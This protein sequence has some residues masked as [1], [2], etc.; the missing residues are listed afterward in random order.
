MKEK[1]KLVLNVVLSSILYVLSY[2]FSVAYFIKFLDIL[3]NNTG[4]SWVLALLMWLV[5][6]A[7]FLMNSIVLNSDKEKLKQYNQDN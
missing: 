5:W 2:I 3:I 4:G 1:T 7:C 6:I